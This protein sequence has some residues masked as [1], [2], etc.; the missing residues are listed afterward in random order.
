MVSITPESS[1]GNILRESLRQSEE[2]IW[3]VSYITNEGYKTVKS[4]VE[5]FSRKS[6]SFII[7][8]TTEYGITSPDALSE[9]LD[10]LRESKSVQLRNVNKINFHAKV[11]YF[12][13][14]NGNV[15]LISGS[16]NLSGTIDEPNNHSLSLDGTEAKLLKLLGRKES[17]ELLNCAIPEWHNWFKNSEE[18]TYEK[19][20]KYKEKRSKSNIGNEIEKLFDKNKQP[21][22]SKEM[23]SFLDQSIVQD[24]PQELLEEYITSNRRPNGLDQPIESSANIEKLIHN[25]NEQHALLYKELTGVSPLIKLGIEGNDWQANYQ[26]EGLQKGAFSIRFSN[27]FLRRLSENKE[28]VLKVK[29]AITQLLNNFNNEEKEQI[30]IIREYQQKIERIAFNLG[31]VEPKE[32]PYKW[33]E[34]HLT[35][36]RSDYFEFVDYLSEK[37][38]SKEE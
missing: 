28:E 38:A 21:G 6:N 4:E 11:Y 5:S 14:V 31:L 36:K 13:L 10:I 35:G 3:A 15:R 7:L 26:L 12:K 33:H 29:E 8:F 27:A 19:N 2:A 23:H 17:D 30:K 9:L 16:H 32:Y 37:S 34:R 24:T 22:F 20:E 25:L 18:W 1:I